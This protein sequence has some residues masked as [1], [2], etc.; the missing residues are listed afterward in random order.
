VRI[1]FSADSFDGGAAIHAALTAVG[2]ELIRWEVG[3][4]APE[5]AR[6]AI[7]RGVAELERAADLTCDILALLAASELGSVLSCVRRPNDYVLLPA[8]P[9]DVVLRVGLFEIGPSWHERSHQRMLAAAVDQA[10]DVIELMDPEG[11]LEYVNP[12][13]ER[14]FGCSA[15]SVVG[16]L[17]PHIAGVTA[18]STSTLTKSAIAMSRGK[19][20]SGVLVADLPSGERKHF[21]SSITPMKD[22]RGNLTHYVAVKR[23]ITERLAD[24]AALVD[25]NNALQRARDAAVTAN[26]AKSEFLANMSHELRT[27]LNAIIG[28]SEMVS[29]DLAEDA[30]AREDLDRVISAARH[31][32]SLINEVLDLAKVE[33][34]KVQVAPEEVVVATLAR[35]AIDASRPLAEQNDTRL[36]LQTSEAPKEIHSDPLRLRQVLQNLLSNACKFTEHGEVKLTVVS[37]ERDGAPWIQFRVSDTGIGIARDVQVRLFEPFVQADASVSRRYGG[38]GLG[39]AITRRLC[40]LLGG[41]VT[42]DSKPGVGSTFTVHLPCAGPTGR[43]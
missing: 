10:T 3:A 27:P 34:Q 33:A 26:Q 2:H 39:L 14:S 8:T 12:A 30:Q 13:Y 17:A 28:Y 16:E 6:L 15:E 22:L 41:E 19:R 24:R 11:T 9:E 35:E 18:D 40:E 31:L 23:D 5:D 4:P 43:L 20:W 36:E 1:L 29:E 32:L 38:T 25:A 7:V 21:E 37:D 42:L